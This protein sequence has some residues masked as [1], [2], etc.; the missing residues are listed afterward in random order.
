MHFLDLLI[1]KFC[2]LNQISLNFAFED[3]IYD[4]L[5]QVMASYH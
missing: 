4:M 3:P 2:V 1:E 5:V